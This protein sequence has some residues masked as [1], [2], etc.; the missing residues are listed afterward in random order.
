MGK[1]RNRLRKKIANALKYRHFFSTIVIKEFKV[2]YAQSYLGMSWLVFEP[3]LLVLTL[4]YIFTLIGRK[5]RGGHPFPMFFYSGLLSWNF[6]IST[7][8]QGANAFIK[9]AALIKKVY[10]PREISVLKTVT[11]NFIDYLFA[12]IAFIVIMIIYNYSPNWYYLYIPVLLCLQALFAYGIALFFASIS[13]YVRDIRIIVTTLSKVWFWFTPII[14]HYPFEGRTKILYYVNPMAG[15][16][17]NFRTVILDASPPIFKQLYSICAAT[18]LLLIVS[19]T[20]FKHLE[21]EFVDVL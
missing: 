19:A 15:I 16:I 8:V 18:V 20:V 10:F 13:V 12:N 17:S 6:F 3:L 9:D 11:V 7:F 2:R 21:K 14:F 5:A 1:G 4:S